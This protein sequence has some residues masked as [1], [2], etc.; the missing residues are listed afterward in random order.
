[1][2][3]SGSS[4][5]LLAMSTL[6]AIELGERRIMPGDEVIT[7]AC[8]FPTTIN[9]IIQV[10]AVPVFV[11]VDI[12]S[13]NT[14]LER[15]QEALSYKTKAVILTHTLGRP[16]DVKV[17]ADWCKENNLWLIEDCCD[18]L[19]SEVNGRKCGSFGDIGTCSF[20]PAKYSKSFRDWGRDCWCEPGSDNTCGRR[21]VSGYDHKYT[22]SRIGY[23][24]Q[25][26]D[27]QAAVGCAQIAQ[28]SYFNAVR[29]RNY[30]MLLEGVK[31]LT[32]II[33][34]PEYVDGMIPFGFPVTTIG[35][36]RP[37]V[38]FLEGAGIATRPLFAGN[39]TRHP[40]MDGVNYRVSGDLT[41]SDTVYERT[42]WVGCWHGLTEKHIQYEIEKF[43]DYAHE[44]R[45]RNS[46]DSLKS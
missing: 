26:T 29:V 38:E 16:Y 45:F 43:R 30:R 1:M 36:R 22:Y 25:M 20:F 42:F 21:F 2:C 44:I 9:P 40:A 28:L 12:P 32:D 37:M 4:A 35:E 39:I 34:P 5:N 41:N 13:Y 10:G 46:R 23:N 24:L 33:I 31:D 14:T 18:A 7:A 8:G 6:T 17:I 15:L 19:G 11:D 3:N 27:M